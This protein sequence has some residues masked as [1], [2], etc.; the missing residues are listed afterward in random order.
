MINKY[1][2]RNSLGTRAHLKMRHKHTKPNSLSKVHDGC[3][4]CCQSEVVMCR[5]TCSTIKLSQWTTKKSFFSL[6]LFIIENIV[7]VC[8][9]VFVVGATCRAL[10]KQVN[11]Q[12]CNRIKSLNH[13]WFPSNVVKWITT[14]V[15]L[16]TRKTNFI[17][18]F[19]N[20]ISYLLQSH[21]MRWSPL[22]SHMKHFCNQKR[23]FCS[24]LVAFSVHIKNI[25]VFIGSTMSKFYFIEGKKNYLQKWIVC[26]TLQWLLSLWFFW[27]LRFCFIS[28]ISLIF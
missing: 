19:A 24:K 20:F 23:I 14:C 21:S 16:P 28:V 5:L 17:S 3:Y 6:R 25:D 26:H 4:F 11:R 9:V 10:N 18:F 7:S 15:A 8:F 13:V 1:V 27:F 2:L 22:I 12:N